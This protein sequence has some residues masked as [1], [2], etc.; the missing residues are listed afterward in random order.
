MGGLIVSKSAYGGLETCG[1]YANG[2]NFMTEADD[3]DTKFECAAIMEGGTSHEKPMA[4]LQAAVEKQFGAPGQCN[5]GF[6]RHDSLLIVVILTDEC[7]GPGCPG[8]IIQPEDKSPGGPSDWFNAV[9]AARG[10]VESNIVVLS[11]LQYD[12]GAC[13]P[14]EFPGNPDV[15]DEHDGI[16]VKEFTEMFTYGIVGGICEPDFGPYFQ[17]AIEVIDSACDDYVPPG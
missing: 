5:E 17:D 9:V 16:R 6:L 1:P 4:N 13:P 7:D 11:L 2:L 10:G 12:G 8:G 14:P 3:L 15:H